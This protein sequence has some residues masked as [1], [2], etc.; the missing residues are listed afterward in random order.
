MQVVEKQGKRKIDGQKAYAL[1]KERFGAQVADDSVRRTVAQSWIKEALK[2]HGVKSVD[3]RNTEIVKALED[4][5][6]VTRETK[7]A[8]EV[9]PAVKLLK[10]SA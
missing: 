10:E 2:K 8:P 7:L 5:G 6:A 1:I 9:V 4:A 3:K